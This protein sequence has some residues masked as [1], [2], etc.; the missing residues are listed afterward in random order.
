MTSSTDGR[1]R[2]PRRLW[3]A[4]FVLTTIAAS[5]IQLVLLPLVFP[6]WDSGGGVVDNCLDCASYHRIAVKMAADIRQDGWSAWELRP[7]GHTPAGLAAALYAISVPKLWTMIP[8]N[9]AVHATTVTLLFLILTSFG[10]SPR[11]ATWGTIPFALFPSSALWYA[12]LLKDGF[13]FLGFFL[14]LRGWLSVMR[15]PE[16]PR[17]T[18]VHF[19][20]IGEGLIGGL[21]LWV[22]RPEMVKLIL[23]LA[24][25]VCLAALCASQVS[26]RWKARRRPLL[27]GCVLILATGAFVAGLEY[28]STRPDRSQSV[29]APAALL[30]VEHPPQAPTVEKEPEPL[31][32]RAA[33]TI[34]RVT[35][36]LRALASVPA[37]LTAGVIHKRQ[38]YLSEPGASSLDLDVRVETLPELIAFLPRATRNAFLSPFPSHWVGRGTYASTT[39]LRRVCG[40]EMLVVYFALAFVPFAFWRRRAD[41]FLWVILV[42]SGAVLVVLGVIINNW[43]TLYRLRYGYLMLWV[44]IGLCGFLQLVTDLRRRRKLSNQPG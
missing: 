25:V 35:A 8:V 41:V 40:L 5:L 21:L 29:S 22:I 10:Y 11:N 39:S 7:E 4:V 28:A 14:F 13:F 6:A 23:G 15:P 30:N 19:L 16:K 9:A 38:A 31:V 24:F 37:R 33:P 18:R 26:A 32:R 3:W 42:Y 12:Q 1:G 36:M 20:S 34:G 17:Q 2:F 44:G 27:T 43:G